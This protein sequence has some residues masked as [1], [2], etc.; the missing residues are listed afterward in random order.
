VFQRVFVLLVLTLVMLPSNSRAEEILSHP[1]GCPRR[2]FCGCGASVHLF[3]QPVRGLFLSSNW[4]KFPR[5]APAHN[6]VAVRRGHVFVLKQ[7]V[8]GNTWLVFD[9]NSG[10]RATRMHNRSIA[11]YTIVNPGG[12]SFSSAMASMPE[13]EGGDAPRTKRRRR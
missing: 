5:T 9:A 7:Q 2:A 13:G 6:M 3:G 4:L 8:E 10:G 11:G 1:A 12:G